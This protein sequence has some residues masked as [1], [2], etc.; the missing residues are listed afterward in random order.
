[1]KDY[2]EVLDVPRDASSED[3]KRAFRQL[4][5]ESHPDANPGDSSAEERDRKSVV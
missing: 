3:I 2:Y 5:R 1:M 4:A